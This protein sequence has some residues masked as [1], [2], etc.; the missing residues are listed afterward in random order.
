[1]TIADVLEALTKKFPKHAGTIA[2]W[3][4]NYTRVLANVPE[5]RLELVLNAVLDRWEKSIA[6][7]PA[8]FVEA[9]TAHTPKASTGMLG[10]S[11]WYRVRQRT[12]SMVNRF[13]VTLPTTL[14][15]EHRAHVLW[16]YK[17]KAWL[18]AQQIEA[19]KFPDGT[20]VVLTQADYDNARDRFTSQR[21]NYA[22]CMS[23]GLGGF[24]T[25]SGTV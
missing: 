20:E 10:G 21:D 24:K 16:I 9:A 11:F 18:L 13:E 25:L 15:I 2:E 1:M 7:L 8:D 6:P 22:R 17:D 5:D 3:T 23:R 4:K 19:G 14:E 12:R